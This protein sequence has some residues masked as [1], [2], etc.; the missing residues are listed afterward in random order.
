MKVLMATMHEPHPPI[1]QFRPDLSPAFVA[2]IDRCLDKRQENRF[3]DAR[4]LI[5]ALKAVRKSISPDSAFG[6]EDEGGSA[7]D[8]ETGTPYVATAIVHPSTIKPGSTF[9]KSKLPLIGGAA[10]AVVLA[11]GAYAI[12]GGKPKEVVV[13]PT[14][15]DPNKV[16]TPPVDVVALPAS[17]KKLVIDNVR[18]NLD[19]ANEFKIL[20]K[21]DEAEYQYQAAVASLANNGKQLP[22]LVKDLDEM[23]KNID[24]AKKGDMFDKQFTAVD[25]A[26]KNGNIDEAKNLVQS[27]APVDATQVEAMN[28]KVAEITKIEAKAKFKD[29][30]GKLI[31]E[32]KTNKELKTSE[33]IALVNKAL[34]KIND[35]PHALELLKTLKVTQ[36]KEMTEEK[37]KQT[38]TKARNL[39]VQQ[40]YDAGRFGHQR[41]VDVEAGRQGS[42]GAGH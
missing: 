3:A 22:D 38:V 2:L 40:N 9:T 4:Q 34:E 1:T 10:A 39:Y 11:V 25:L 30:V 29:E 19:S 28:K 8:G 17:I 14:N 20:K 16:I 36:Q 41:S 6:G 21:W 32:A 26:L 27:L 35:D 15:P 12:F 33:R 42:D 7:D 37:F 13:V 31:F 23:R 18:K 24:M 5:R